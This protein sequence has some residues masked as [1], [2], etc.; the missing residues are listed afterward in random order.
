[1]KFGSNAVNLFPDIP[2]SDTEREDDD[3][4]WVD[5]SFQD[6]IEKSISET[7]KAIERGEKFLYQPSFILGDC[8][9]RAD[10]MIRNSTGSYDLYEVKAKSHI[11]K[12]VKNKGEDQNIGEIE[13]CFINDVS[14]QKYVIDEIFKSW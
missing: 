9:V 13:K 3:D 12:S 2:E 1:M 11:R 6:R 5:L 4:T 10:Y 7:E 14:F 8:Y